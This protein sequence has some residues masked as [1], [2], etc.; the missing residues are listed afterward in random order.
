MKDWVTQIC[1]FL[2]TES[3]DPAVVSVA[4]AERVIDVRVL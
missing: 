3:A 2:V 1:G 4:L